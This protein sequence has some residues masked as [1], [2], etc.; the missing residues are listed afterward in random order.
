P[1]DLTPTRAV[2]R[3]IDIP[4]KKLRAERLRE[5]HEVIASGAD[6]YRRVF[7]ANAILLDEM[8][9]ISPTLAVE[10]QA[11]QI[12]PLVVV[13]SPGFVFCQFG[14]DTKSASKF[15]YTFVA[16][17]ANGDI[18]YVPTDDAYGPGG[19]GYEQRNAKVGPGAGRQI[20]E[21]WLEL[22]EGLEPGAVPATETYDPWP[23]EGLPIGS[24][25]AR[26]PWNYGA[27]G[28]DDL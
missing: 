27:V 13:S 26:S 22:I 23:D 19:G 16:T 24:A 9:K 21:T 20:Q 18:G 1:G 17:F 2:T 14:L 25:G 6:D 3:V 15:P 5:A 28:P 8:S 4:Y 10:L 12:G 7:A 11:V